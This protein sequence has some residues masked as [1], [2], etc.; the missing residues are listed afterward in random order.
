MLF[1]NSVNN[2]AY[3]LL[4]AIPSLSQID[5]VQQ[6]TFF[7]YVKPLAKDSGNQELNGIGLK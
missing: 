2:I 4:M 6:V 1:D 5:N 7:S 3:T